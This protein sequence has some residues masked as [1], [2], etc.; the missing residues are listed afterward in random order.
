[1]PSFSEAIGVIVTFIVLSTASGHGDV[2][3]KTIGGI[4]RVAMTNARRD[5]GCPSIFNKG[6]CN[7]YNSKRYR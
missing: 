1:M 7:S 3:W 5:F 6:A 4:R 2:A